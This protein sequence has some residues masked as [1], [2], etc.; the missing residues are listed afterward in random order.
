M[1]LPF[2]RPEAPEIYRTDGV[3]TLLFCTSEKGRLTA[4]AVYDG[5]TITTIGSAL[6]SEN[7]NVKKL[8]VS[9][10]ITAIE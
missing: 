8:I 5:I 10:G 9:E 2:E 4:P 3:D 1:K 7:T 6:Y